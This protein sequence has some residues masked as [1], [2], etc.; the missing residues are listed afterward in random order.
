MINKNKKA[1]MEWNLIITMIVILIAVGFF[2]VKF[3]FKTSEQ[4]DFFQSC[5][6]NGDCK[7]TCSINELE[8]PIFSCETP[9]HKCCIDYNEGLT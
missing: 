8:S 1:A 6:G 9:G 3:V 5:D 4:S 2:L 7:S